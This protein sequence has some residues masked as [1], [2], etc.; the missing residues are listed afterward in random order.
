MLRAPHFSLHVLSALTLLAAAG[1]HDGQ[2]PTGMDADAPDAQPALTAAADNTLRDRGINPSDTYF[3]LELTTTRTVEGG[4]AASRG[5]LADGSYSPMESVYI[6]TGYGSDGQL[7]FNLYGSGSTNPNIQLPP[8][9]V[10][11]IGNLISFYDESGALTGQ[12]SFHEFMDGAGL[13]GGDLASGTPRG[14]L[15]NPPGGVDHTCVGCDVAAPATTIAGRGGRTR[16]IRPRSNV[17]QIVTTVEPDGLGPQRTA[18]RSGPGGVQTTRTFRRRVVPE[19]DST[20]GVRARGPGQWVLE[21]V[22]RTSQVPTPRGV[23]TTRTRSAYR[24]VAAHINPGRDKKRGEALNN[25]P[26]IQP[27]AP[28]ANRAEST[29]KITA[30][31]RDGINLCETLQNENTVRYV[32]GDGA[33]VV[34]QHGF[35]SGAGTWSAM[36]QRVPDTHHV[37][38][39]QAYSLNPDA[40]IESQASDLIGRLISVG[41]PGSVVVAHSQGGLVAR[42]VGQ[43]RP[44]LVSG[45]VTIA[46]PHEGAL[47]A[48]NA[49]SV[50]ANQ[51]RNAAGEYCFGDWMCD[52]VAETLLEAAGRYV[53]HGTGTLIPAAGDDQPG[54]AL[55]QRV[56]GRSEPQYETFRRVSISMSVPNRWALFRLIG[57]GKTHR[58]RLLNNRPLEG[59]NYVQ[60]ADAVYKA[61]HLMEFMAMTIRWW[62]ASDGF[63]WGCSQPGY[64]TYWEPCYNA[65]DYTAHWRTENYWNRVAD[66]LYLI[67][68]IVTNGL[69]YIDG[70]WNEITTAGRY[71][72]DGFVHLPSQRYPDVPGAFVPIRHTIRGEEA[73]SGETASADVLRVLRDAL[74]DAGVPRN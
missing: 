56:N 3:A 70:T 46:T 19:S 53:T 44:D 74:P 38:W 21:S 9:L 28:A 64:R 50:I 33:P 66:V 20:G 37:G 57:D 67:G 31:S 10:Q 61:G 30:A 35:C 59:R 27:P 14:T 63:G 49:P 73:H 26:G 17:L 4:A 12:Y 11:T 52:L 34:Y 32:E 6:E 25:H 7:R 39:E 69:D 51:L 40:P 29:G 16:V 15:Y 71:G 36:R 8:S 68:S 60:R 22:E 13:P 48:A 1:C 43:R 65:A 72:T 55:I 58:S 24:Y 2:M 41:V 5:T 47:V 23:V 42:R 62:V 18:D 45:L 54:S